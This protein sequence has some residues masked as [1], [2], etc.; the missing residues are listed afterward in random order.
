MKHLINILFVL[1]ALSA[2]GQ[3]YDFRIDPITEQTELP[4]LYDMETGSYAPVLHETYKDRVYIA[5]NAQRLVIVFIHDTAGEFDNPYLWKAGKNIMGSTFTG[6]PFA[7]VHSHGTHCAG[8]VAGYSPQFP[9][10]VASPLTE[11]D[12][13]WLVPHKVLTNEGYGNYSWVAESL[14]DATAKGKEYTKSKGAFIIHSLSLGGSTSDA[15]LQK[16]ITEA[17]EAGQLVVIAAGNTGATPIQFPGRAENANAICAVDQAGKR[18]YFSSFGKEAFISGAGVSVL[19]TLPSGGLGKK[20]GTSM[21]TPAI[22]GF[23]AVVASLNPDAT[24]NQIERFLAKYADPGKWDKYK[25]WGIPKW[26]NYKG[27]DATTEPDTPIEDT[28]EEPETE[29]PQRAER[30]VEFYLPTY[31]II[32]KRQTGEKFYEVEVDFKVSINTKFYDADAYD[33]IKK[34]FDWFFC[35]DGSCGRAIVLSDQMGFKDAGYY[36]GY[37]GEMLINKRKNGIEP[38]KIQEIDIQDAEG[39]S[40]HHKRQAGE[41]LGTRV[42]MFGLRALKPY[43]FEYKTYD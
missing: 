11:K 7:D 17:R 39:R 24:A 42:S 21:A 31:S 32:W 6:E 12:L 27:K 14:K 30:F 3:K 25:G 19:S 18:A 9:L 2:F 38:I 36:A 43:T 1:L 34:E 26:T 13:I 8:I 4:S 33:L 35:A 28:P 20:S 41:K 22:A 23:V 29:Y 10:G 37:F 40:A 5:N 16:A 15:T